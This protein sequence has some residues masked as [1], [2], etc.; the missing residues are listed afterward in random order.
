M[1]T[2][3]LNFPFAA[4]KAQSKT[5]SS[6]SYVLVSMLPDAYKTSA[7]IAPSRLVSAEE[8]ASYVAF[9]TML[10]A[11]IRLN[12]GELSSAMLARYLKRLNAEVNS[13]PGTKTEDTLAKLT[14]QNYLV[15]S[16]D[17]D[18]RQHG[19]EAAA[20]TWTVGP[21]GKVEVGDEAVASFIRE[22]WG[23]EGRNEELESRLRA[24]LSIRDR[25]VPVQNRAND[26]GGDENESR[27]VQGDGERENGAPEDGGP[28]RRSGRRRRVQ[29]EE[30]EEEDE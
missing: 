13:F 5:N 7:I 24:T 22:I 26:A 1:L 29:E 17:K 2:V 27:V 15:K 4:L 21:R 10:I 28:S 12:G 23:S 25:D 30:E 19:E 6:N 20:T 3:C 8:E 9:Y 14:R 16:V 18:A 11:L